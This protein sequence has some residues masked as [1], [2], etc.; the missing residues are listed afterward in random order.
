VIAANGSGAGAQNCVGALADDAY[1]VT[2]PFEGLSNCPG[3][4][5]DPKLGPLALNGG[6]LSTVRIGA[7]SSAIDLEPPGAPVRSRTS[8]VSHGRRTAAA[9]PA[10]TSRRRH[11]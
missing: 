4:V 7:G 9:T 11:S 5:S 10:P 1:N 2:Y 8:A 3:V 6:A